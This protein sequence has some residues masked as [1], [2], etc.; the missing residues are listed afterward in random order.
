MALASLIFCK[1]TRIGISNFIFLTHLILLIAPNIATNVLLCKEDDCKQLGRDIKESMNPTVN[2]CD[3]FYEFVC[4]NW[5]NGF[6]D[7]TNK[8]SFN[9]LDRA[10]QVANERLKE[11]IEE[12]PSNDIDSLMKAKEWHK[13]CV[14]DVTLSQKE[15]KPIEEILKDLGGWPTILPHWDRRDW[16]D[17]NNQ[18]TITSAGESPFYKIDTIPDLESDPQRVILELSPPT[19]L[20]PTNVLLDPNTND[21]KF[22]AYVDFFRKIVDV[23]LQSSNIHVDPNVIITDLVEMLVLEMYLT[24]AAKDDK[25]ADSALSI[26]LTIS[27]L[28]YRYNEINGNNPKS[29]IN[30]LDVLRNAVGIVGAQINEWEEVEVINIDYFDKLPIILYFTNER[31]I[32]NHIHWQFVS[33]WIRYTTPTLREL[34]QKFTNEMTSNTEIVPRWLECIKLNPFDRAITYEYLRKY[35]PDANKE[36]FEHILNDTKFALGQQISNANW[37]DEQSKNASWTKLMSIVAMLEGPPMYRNPIEIDEFYSQLPVVPDSFFENVKNQRYGTFTR[38]LQMNVDEHLE[39]DEWHDMSVGD[40]LYFVDINTLYFFIPL[41][42]NPMFISGSSNIVQLYNYGFVGSAIA[43]E[44]G[45]VFDDTGRY[46]NE[47]GQEAPLW[48]LATNEQFKKIRSCFVE[49]F[50]NYDIPGIRNEATGQPIKEDG[51]K[52]FNENLADAIGLRAAF[53]AFQEKSKNLQ[54]ERLPNLEKYDNN[55]LFFISYANRLC[56][57]KKPDELKDFYSRK[58]RQHSIN[59]L[60]VNAELSNMEAFSQ[61]FKC[62]QYDKMNQQSKCNLW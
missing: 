42:T 44:F 56:D 8:S 37:M 36:T 57:Y 50:N 19:F 48:S 54:L 5:R 17:I 18:Y 34:F 59:S 45:Y 24:E 60:R 23:F 3:D 27:E 55:Q 62:Q 41:L 30:W 58:D 4:G 38:T 12:Q 49:Q 16:Q 53:A 31:A 61:V 47:N 7:I 15:V 6:P 29:Q 1:D 22:N 39:D 10:L 25:P 35:V 20:I 9:L 13:I 32:V 21:K 51:E 52:T 43:H 14:D 26:R 2:P 46:F 11:I 40:S 33:H 28:Q